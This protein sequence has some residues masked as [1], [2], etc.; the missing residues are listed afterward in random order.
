MSTSEAPRRPMKLERL[1]FST[2]DIIGNL[3]AV[4]DNC[5]Y[6]FENSIEIT[7]FNLRNGEKRTITTEPV[8]QSYDTCGGLAWFR[9]KLH[10]IYEDD[11]GTWSAEVCHTSESEPPTITRKKRL[12]ESETT[13]VF[14]CS[15]T[16]YHIDSEL[17]CLENYK[18]Y[19]GFDLNLPLFPYE[20][21]I[22]S[23]TV[24]DGEDDD[25]MFLNT[26]QFD[27]QHVTTQTELRQV[28]D[29]NYDLVD[30]NNLSF[31][32]G[33][34]TYIWC[35]DAYEFSPELWIIDHAKNTIED[36]SDRVENI[37]DLG[38]I[39]SIVNDGNKFYILTDDRGLWKLSL[40]ETDT[41]EI[42]PNT[43]SSVDPFQCPV[44]WEPV[45]VPKLFPCGHTICGDCEP[46]LRDS[47]DDFKCPKC[48]TPV[49]LDDDQTLPT[50]W[51]LIEHLENIKKTKS[52]STGSCSSCQKPCDKDDFFQCKDC[53]TSS[54]N[55][56]LLCGACIARNHR[57]HD[58]EE[59]VF[60]DNELKEQ[61]ILAANMFDLNT[62]D[63][64]EAIRS[65]I[66]QLTALADQK[67]GMLDEIE[68]AVDAKTKKIRSNQFLTK[69]QLNVEAEEL[70]L[71]IIDAKHRADIIEHW[72]EC[73]SASIDESKE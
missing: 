12:R 71:M 27:D 29:I 44:C 60:V 6:Y 42:I 14:Q 24:E 62:S 55:E 25:K 41:V 65:L 58:Y 28:S 3:F 4:K 10:M 52:V 49:E 47:D 33:D 72:I 26:F 15:P 34:N 48:R 38:E 5:V 36:V 51:I 18:M 45:K 31:V 30:R 61:A 46:R 70:M 59:M 19:S 69:E 68:A 22:C 56:G 2:R 32:V 11:D 1:P 9:D 53:A 73:L 67:L 37:D 43:L 40:E 39:L 50:N 13:N 57:R 16:L 64:K 66:T 63:R 54:T 35:W 17:F 21:R 7:V 8:T 23:I 20:S